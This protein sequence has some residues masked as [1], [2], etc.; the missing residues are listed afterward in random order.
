M[1]LAVGFC[2]ADKLAFKQHYLNPKNLADI[3]SIT[4]ENWRVITIR[5]L[6]K[7][8]CRSL[9]SVDAPK[10][11]WYAGMTEQSSLEQDFDRYCDDILLYQIYAERVIL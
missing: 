4:T 8:Y 1:F 9:N 6:Y 11:L 3:Y 7:T 5:N 2:V 10:D